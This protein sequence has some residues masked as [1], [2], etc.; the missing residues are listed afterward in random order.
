V[1]EG[2]ATLIVNASVA[3]PVPPALVALNVTDE[4]PV[5][6]GVPEIKPPAGSTVSPAGSPV[7]P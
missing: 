1:I 5:A 4:V 6:V 7:A 2:A 3:V